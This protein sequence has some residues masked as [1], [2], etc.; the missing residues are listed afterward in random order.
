MA[1]DKRGYRL[2]LIR[3]S[4]TK[5]LLIAEICNFVDIVIVFSGHNNS[6]GTVIVARTL[7]L[8]L[9]TNI[10]YSPAGSLEDRNNN[11]DDDQDRI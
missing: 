5:P 4:V 11:A 10:S 1:E 6:P 2:F 7:P 3:Y 9:S 8:I